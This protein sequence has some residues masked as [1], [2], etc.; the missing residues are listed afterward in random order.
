MADPRT[1][2]PVTISL[3]SVWQRIRGQP[4]DEKLFT[5]AGIVFFAGSILPWS[6]GTNGWSS[7]LT[8]LTSLAV[9]CGLLVHVLALAGVGPGRN[10]GFWRAYRWAGAG[11]VVL[12]AV[13]FLGRI[14][15]P[16]E[17]A[18]GFWLCAMSMA[19]FAN[20]LYRLLDKRR[21][22]PFRITR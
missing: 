4:L 2:E 17:Q 1:K 21:L 20:A 8:A 14:A 9:V 7:S 11:A 15:S 5:W 10:D 12:F 18:L 13:S 3:G 6:P 16:R 22:L 19:V